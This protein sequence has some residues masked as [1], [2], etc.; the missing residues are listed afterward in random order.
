M[1][2]E[3]VPGRDGGGSYGLRVL[4]CLAVLLAFSGRAFAAGIELQEQSAAA[5]ARVLAVRAWLNDPS[6]VF[7]NPAGLAFLEGYSFAVGDT[8]VFPDFNYSDPD[9]VHADAT[10]ANDLVAPPHGYFAYGKEL[11]GG[12]RLGFGIGANYPF[13]L[14]LEWPREFAGSYVTAAS[15]LQIP[16]VTFGA[17]FAPIPDFSFGAAFVVSPAQVYLKKYMGPEFGLVGDDGQPIRDAFVEM[18]GGGTGFGFNAGLQ[19]RRDWLYLGLVYR[20]AISLEMEGDAHFDLPGLA[21][22]SA[23]PDQTVKT[24]FQLPPIVAAGV[25]ARFGNLYSEVDVD[26]TFWSVFEKVPLMFPDDGT[27]QLSQEIPEDWEDGWTFRWGNEYAASD[28]LKLRIGAGFDQN[29]ATDEFLSP[30]L[31]DS[32]RAFVAAGAGYAFD[33]GMSVDMSY[34]FTQFLDRTVTGRACTDADQ[35]CLQPDGSFDPYD[36]DGALRWIGNRFPA[37]YKSH[38]QLVAVTL[39]ARF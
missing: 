30:M 39:G 10:S 35:E 26:Y 14:T 1:T 28:A 29:P 19:A 23:F 24:E 17:A 16:E 8:M 36:E 34:M 20:H 3:V 27:G 4:L 22:R 25:G 18:A 9:G 5:Q 12:G 11:A 31:P 13:G 37:T 7:Y 6:V 15:E 21:D 38:A 2:S 32:D 33:N